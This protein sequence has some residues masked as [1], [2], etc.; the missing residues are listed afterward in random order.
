TRTPS[1]GATSA[2]G[3]TASPGATPAPSGSTVEVESP[4]TTAA[5]A[6]SIFALIGIMVVSTGSIVRSNHGNG[7][8]SS[9]GGAGGASADGSRGLVG[10]AGA[11]APVGETGEGDNPPRV[12]HR[13]PSATL[14]FVLMTQLQFLAMLSLVDYVVS[15]GS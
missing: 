13:R 8:V 11:I 2:P 14:A 12:S 3:A 6:V 4:G 5:G 15:Q 9:A 7:S 10:T 1:P